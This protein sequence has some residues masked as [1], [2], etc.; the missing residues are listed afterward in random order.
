MHQAEFE[1]S[2]SKASECAFR[3]A[4][5]EPFRG[6]EVCLCATTIELLGDRRRQA[7]PW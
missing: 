6:L 3:A 7:G 1:D 4:H 2:S 5:G